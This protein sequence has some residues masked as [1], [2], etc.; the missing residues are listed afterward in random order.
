MKQFKILP[1]LTGNLTD[2]GKSIFDTFYLQDIESGNAILFEA[3]HKYEAFT[4]VDSYNN[5]VVSSGLKQIR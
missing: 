3:K 5:D 4:V 2:E 1:I